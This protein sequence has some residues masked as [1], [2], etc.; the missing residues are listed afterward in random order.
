[1]ARTFQIIELNSLDP[2]GE[3]NRNEPRL[4][5]PE[6]LTAARAMKDQ[7]KAFRVLYQGGVL[8]YDERRELHDLGAL[9]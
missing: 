6:A 5:Y 4:A 9:W 3:D 1:M 2:S 8:S 7:G